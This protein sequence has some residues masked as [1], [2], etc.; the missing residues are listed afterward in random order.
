MIFTFASQ[1]EEAAGQ[2][3]NDFWQKM[4]KKFGGIFFCVFRESRDFSA[5]GEIKSFKYSTGHKIH[6]GAGPVKTWTL[7]NQSKVALLK[8]SVMDLNFKGHI[9]KPCEFVDMCQEK[10]VQP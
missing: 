5:E 4:W 6:R 8:T 3:R 10:Q 1:S 2:Q 7:V 9:W